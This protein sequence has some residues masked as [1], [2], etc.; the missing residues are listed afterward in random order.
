MLWGVGDL[1]GCFIVDR[2]HIY[3]ATHDKGNFL[4]IRRNCDIGGPTCLELVDQV[5]LHL[6]RNDPDIHFLWLCA[7]FDRI[8]FTV[9]PI[10]EVTVAVGSQETDGMRG[11]VGYLPATFAGQV[12]LEYIKASFFF[13]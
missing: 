7:L 3:I 10:T 4:S 6:V 13:A 11:M 8:D 12:V 1:F 2:S 5:V 9:I